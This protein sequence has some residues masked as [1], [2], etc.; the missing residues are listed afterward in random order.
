M[1]IV[2]YE[3]EAPLVKLN[4][5]RLAHVPGQTAAELRALHYFRD[6]VAERL[7]GYFDTR[8]WADLV[9]QVAHSVAS[10]RHAI[11][12][13]SSHWEAVVVPGMHKRST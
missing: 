7:A 6:V 9:L 1:K 13:V 4:V 12:A 10:L 11:I 3:P 2:F 5:Q 8:F